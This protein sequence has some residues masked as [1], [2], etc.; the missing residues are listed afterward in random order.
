MYGAPRRQDNGI[1][2]LFEPGSNW[3]IPLYSCVS[4]AKATIKT[5]YFRFN[6]SEDLSGVAVTDIQDKVY[7]DDAHKP[8]WGVEQTNLTLSDVSPLWG[9]ISSSYNG[10]ISL[11][12]VRK[13]SLYLPG[14]SG[15]SPEVPTSPSF[16]NLPGTSFYNAAIGTALNIGFSSGFGVADY[17]GQTNSAM[18][19]QWQDL[20]QSAATSARILNLVWTDVAAN[21][22]IGTRTLA[23]QKG[24]AKRGNNNSNGSDSLFPSVVSYKRRVQYHYPYGIPAFLTLLFTV[25]LILASLAAALLGHSGPR[26][27][28]RL[29]NKTSLGR[30][31]TPLQVHK[32]EAQ[33]ARGLSETPGTSELVVAATPTKQWRDTLGKTTITLTENE[34]DFGPT[35]PVYH[36]V[37]KSK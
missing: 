24:L 1:S 34:T 6:G 26:T 15:W 5:V 2:L 27:M 23:P 30:V 12:T 8:L 19:R 33:Q 35:E 11:S 37:H 29:L 32:S 36:P 22:V 7:A 18:L 3:T 25:A 21:A 10:N 14:Y 4:T 20:S 13:E 28:R 9:L 31:L 16:Q 17:S